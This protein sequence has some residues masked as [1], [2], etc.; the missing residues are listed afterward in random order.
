LYEVHNQDHDVLL[1]LRPLLV[2]LLFWEAY[3]DVGDVVLLDVVLLRLDVV[4]YAVE[5]IQ[6][7][8]Q[9]H[10]LHVKLLP[11]YDLVYNYEFPC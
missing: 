7:R 10:Y 6:M 3:R 8:L 9:H 5:Q 11:V 2:N 1:L 4:V